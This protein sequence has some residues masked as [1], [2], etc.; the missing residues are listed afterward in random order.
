MG[1][2]DESG[3][4]TGLFNS[5]R[6]WDGVERKRRLVCDECHVMPS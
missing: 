6:N 3:E 2:V 1:V 5:K 4:P